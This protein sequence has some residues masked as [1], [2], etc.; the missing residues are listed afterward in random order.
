MALDLVEL[1][2]CSIDDARVDI[3]K[4]RRRHGRI[5][6]TPIPLGEILERRP[7][8]S[9]LQV[10]IETADQLLHNVLAR[11]VDLDLDARVH[12]QRLFA[13]LR[14]DARDPSVD[15]FEGADEKAPDR[16]AAVA[17]KDD[18]ANSRH[19]ARAQRE[20]GCVV[21]A[22]GGDQHGQGTKMLRGRALPLAALGPRFRPT[23]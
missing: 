17:L 21:A 12:R 20:I 6:T 18:A 4:G 11:T 3:A 7:V 10:H 5:P 8:Q 15:G 1:L 14:Q 22:A 23:E 16:A 13:G 19:L 9:V 2:D